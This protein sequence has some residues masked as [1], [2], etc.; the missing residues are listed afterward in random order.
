MPWR[1]VLD[2]H[3]PWTHWSCFVVWVITAS[4]G[5]V[6]VVVGVLQ[7]SSSWL[8]GLAICGVALVPMGIDSLVVR[9]LLRRNPSW[10]PWTPPR[11]LPGR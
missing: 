9:P 3:P 8:I 2:A 7:G 10:A 11:W 6:A 5:P 4:L 1:Y